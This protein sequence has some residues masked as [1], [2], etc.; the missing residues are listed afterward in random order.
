MISGNMADI[1][2]NLYL[3]YSLIWYHHHYYENNENDK[4]DIEDKQ[5]KHSKIFLKNQCIEYLM[6]EAE[7]KMNLLIENYPIKI[8]SP[9]LYPLKSNTRLP[10]LENKNKLYNLILNDKDLSEIFKKDIYYKGTVL[11][12]MENLKKLDKTTREY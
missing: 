5:D 4:K 6:D 2:S 3:G 12:K 8:F 9:L 11:E 7:Y 1:L 10:I